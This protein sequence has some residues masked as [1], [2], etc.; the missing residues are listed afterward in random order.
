[1]VIVRELTKLYEETWRGSLAAAAERTTTV[2][3]R[4]EHTLVVAG[5][6]APGPATADDVDAALR[7][8][9]AAGHDRKEAVRLVAV[10]LGLP[11]R[12]VYDAALALRA[13][14]AADQP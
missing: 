10:A 13:R 12:Q 7:R 3:P 6:P 1:M 14:E 9:L 8:A 5:A 4:G 2:E 11:R